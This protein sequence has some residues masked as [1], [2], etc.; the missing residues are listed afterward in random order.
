[1]SIP[2]IIDHLEQAIQGLVE[3]F[4][5]V[6]ADDKPPKKRGSYKKRKKKTGW[7]LARRRRFNA[8]RRAANGKDATAA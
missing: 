2:K 3:L 4:M 5:V 7:S 1:M 6:D 8:K